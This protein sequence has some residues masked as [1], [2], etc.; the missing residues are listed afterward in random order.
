MEKIFIVI[1]KTP[2]FK[3]DHNL[4]VKSSLNTHTIKSTDEE[5]ASEIEWLKSAGVKVV[6]WDEA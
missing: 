1:T 2:A 3:G 4:W 6:S 5:I